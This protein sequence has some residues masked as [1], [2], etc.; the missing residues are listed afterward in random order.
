MDFSGVKSIT[1]PEGSVKMITSNGVTLWKKVSYTNLIPLS[2]TSTGAPYVG[3]NG[4]KGYNTGIR[5]DK[6]TGTETSSSTTDA[7]GFIPC[8]HMDKFYFSKGLMPNE[9]TARTCIALYDSNFSLLELESI[10][11]IFNKRTNSTLI[12]Y[13]VSFYDDDTLCTIMPRALSYWVGST[14][15]G[16]TAYVRFVAWKPITASS[17]ITKNQPI[18]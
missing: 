6:S 5:L 18:E 8:G 11:A 13:G 7:V 14:V 17:V 10:Y 9:S 4:E 1:I 16:K 3:A 2:I 15:T 12:N